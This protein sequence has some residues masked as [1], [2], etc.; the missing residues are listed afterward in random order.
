[1]SFIRAFSDGK[2]AMAKRVVAMALAVL[3]GIVAS[4]QAT[5]KT[6]KIL[7]C[8]GKTY[9]YTKDHPT[10]RVSPTKDTILIDDKMLYIGIHV[11]KYGNLYKYSDAYSDLG[12]INVCKIDAEKSSNV[13]CKFDKNSIE[14]LDF[15]LSGDKQYAIAESFDRVEGRWHLSMDN[16][17][18]NGTFEHKIYDGVCTQVGGTKSKLRAF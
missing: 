16:Y 5:A 9:T 13:H 15:N 2:R 18:D 12:Y 10:L 4:Q 17:L 11:K 7:E 6:Y 1:M 14:Y 3:G 8:S